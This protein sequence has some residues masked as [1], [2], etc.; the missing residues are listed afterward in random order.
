MDNNRTGRRRT[1]FLIW[2]AACGIAA[3]LV[4]G[5]IRG[6]PLGPALGRS[7]LALPPAAV[8]ALTSVLGIVWQSRA[9]GT[10]RWRAALD[11]YAEREIARDRRREGAPTPVYADVWRRRREDLRHRPRSSAMLSSRQATS[12]EIMYGGNF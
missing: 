2:L 3:V 5:I 9:R 10:R 7:W 1:M 6:L 4:A 12:K 8:L 11:G